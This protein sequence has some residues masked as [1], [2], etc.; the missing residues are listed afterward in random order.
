MI[1]QLYVLHS[2][3]LFRPS[4][5]EKKMNQKTFCHISFNVNPS[6]DSRVRVKARV[7]TMPYWL[8]IHSHTF[9]LSPCI[10]PSLPNYPCN[11]MQLP[12]PNSSHPKPCGA[13][14]T[15]RLPPVY[16]WVP[17]PTSSRHSKGHGIHAMP[18]PP[19]THPLSLGSSY[20]NHY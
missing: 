14:V 9:F 3:P 1:Q 17:L 11:L 18:S 5:Q 20:P 13:Y 19:L 8:P 6:H 4:C 15:T 10:K 16:S 7:H 2:F 12:P